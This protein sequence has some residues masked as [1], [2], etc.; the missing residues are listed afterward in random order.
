MI[1]CSQSVVA[2]MTNR[3]PTLKQN[4]FHL[5]LP[6]HK[7][8]FLHTWQRCVVRSWA[9]MTKNNN[10][11]IKDQRSIFLELKAYAEKFQQLSN[12][13]VSGWPH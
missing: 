4:L 1:L 5:D 6:Q 12:F 9:L 2:R 13:L 11:P 7:A 8:G 10:I 3:F